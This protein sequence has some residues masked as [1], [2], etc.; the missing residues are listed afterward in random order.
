V[1]QWQPLYLRAPDEA[2]M[3]NTLDAAGLVGTDPETGDQVVGGDPFH[4]RVTVLPPLHEP[5][6]AMID[7]GEDFEYPEMTQVPGYH[8]NVLV[9]QSEE[10][11]YRAALSAVLLEP[12]PI[13]PLVNWMGY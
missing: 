11:H 5:T 4:I 13:T 6:G 3:K 10:A 2:A 8:V 7:D 9:H 12:E 1:S